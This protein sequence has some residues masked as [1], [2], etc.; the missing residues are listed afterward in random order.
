MHVGS[1][2]VG[3]RMFTSWWCGSREWQRDWSL[4]TTF[5]HVLSDLFPPGRPCL[6]VFKVVFLNRHFLCSKMKKHFLCLLL[7]FISSGYTSLSGIFCVWRELN[8]GHH[9]WLTALYYWSI[10]T[11]TNLEFFQKSPSHLSYSQCF[12]LN[13]L[14]L[15]SVYLEKKMWWI[16]SRVFF[17]I[18]WVKLIW[19]VFSPVI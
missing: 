12:I 1:G 4:G 3:Q 8:P 7:G 10:Y 14:F 9:L 11:V 17:L 13:T 18:S 19:N 15:S 2:S 5:S 16:V 6:L